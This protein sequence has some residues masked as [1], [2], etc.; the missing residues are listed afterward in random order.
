[1]TTTRPIRKMMPMALP[2]NFSIPR[3]LLP[4]CSLLH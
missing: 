4:C 2:K 1:M 3:V